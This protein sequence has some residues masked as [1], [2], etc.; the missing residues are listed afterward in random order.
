MVNIIEQLP[1]SEKI[2]FVL[3]LQRAD[4]FL[5]RR[6][7]IDHCISEAS[8][9]FRSKSLLRTWG[10]AVQYHCRI[11]SAS[12]KAEMGHDCIF[13]LIDLNIYNSLLID[14]KRQWSKYFVAGKAFQDRRAGIGRK[15]LQADS[16]AFPADPGSTMGGRAAI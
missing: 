16:L 4:R 7:L 3:T 11:N 5:H 2:H 14:L 9:L 10:K 13:R 12:G 1:F 15:E 6:I 8:S